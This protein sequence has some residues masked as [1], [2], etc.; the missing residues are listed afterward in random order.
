MN[1]SVVDLHKESHQTYSELVGF[2]L[3]KQ[4]K[5]TRCFTAVQAMIQPPL[6]KSSKHPHAGLEEP[7]RKGRDIP[8]DSLIL[9]KP[10]A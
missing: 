4:V 9:F 5:F 8:R 2:S 1:A 6:D 7:A 10:A 3:Q